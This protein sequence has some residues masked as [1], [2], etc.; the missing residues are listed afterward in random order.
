MIAA[1]GECMIELGTPM[2][3][4]PKLSFGGDTLN[5]AVYLARLLGDSIPIDY[6][7]A[8]GDDPYSDD[9]IASWESEGVGVGLVNRISGRLPGLYTIRTDPYGE[10]SFY[11]WRDNSAAKDM[12]MGQFGELLDEK[13]LDYDLI[14]LS[15]V[16]LSILNEAGRDRIFNVIDKARN[17]GAVVVFDSNYRP[18]AWPDRKQ[19]LRVMNKMM[20]LT[21]IALP[22]LDDE[23]KLRG[24][25]SV[26]A[27]LTVLKEFGVSEICL[28]DG[29]NGCNG[30]SCDE[31]FVL[32][33]I[34]QIPIDTT[35]AGD[36]FN[37]C[38]VAMRVGGHD[39]QESATAAIKLASVVIRHRGAIIPI[40]DM[41]ELSSL[42]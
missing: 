7:T 6:I 33:A 8:L 10:R 26:A 5:T 9:M 23:K 31:G 13:L 19:A 18:K 28:K 34:E 40:K 32:P 27:C 15:G 38:Y 22:S 36:S 37:A 21:D 11:Y 42:M 41:P 24:I 39:S 1:I 30:W 3:G 17:A 12:F 16:T 35:A 25:D 14:Y 2:E 20:R 4:S 29:A